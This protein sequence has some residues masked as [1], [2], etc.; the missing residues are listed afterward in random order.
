[1]TRIPIFQKTTS[2]ANPLIPAKGHVGNILRAGEVNSA[3]Q[4]IERLAGTSTSWLALAMEGQPSRKG[5]GIEQLLQP[6]QHWHIDVSFINVSGTFYYLGPGQ[7][8]GWL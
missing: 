7:H 8:S 1:M 2:G 4:P 5:T 3:P 6:H